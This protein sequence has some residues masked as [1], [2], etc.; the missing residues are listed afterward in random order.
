MI[1]IKQIQNNATVTDGTDTVT[2]GAGDNYTCSPPVIN[3]WMELVIDTT[4]S[5]G[6]PSDSFSLSAKGNGLI[7]WGDGT[8]KPFDGTTTNIDSTNTHQYS[9]GGV[10]TVKYKGWLT[11]ANGLASD[12]VKI[13]EFK[14]C[15]AE[16][17]FDTVGNM[18]YYCINMTVTAKDVVNTLS[19]TALRMFSYCLLL[20]EPPKVMTYFMNSV[21]EMFLRASLNSDLGYMDL[22]QCNNF[23]NFAINVTTW[24]TENYGKTLMG[25]LRWDSTTHAPQ[26]GWDLKPNQNFHGGNST[27]IA[28]SEAALAR[29]YLINNLNWTI[30]DGGLL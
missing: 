23:T 9:V 10:Y 28:G 8:I 6:T 7:D 12:G 27:L 16:T 14:N 5:G 11:M 18:F 26:V 1:T 3:E 25:W 30:T 20:V 29:D 13:I 19:N 24:S 15:G 17:S 2:L 4:I 22:R 21:Q